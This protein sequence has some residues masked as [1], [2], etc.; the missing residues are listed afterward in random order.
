MAVLTHAHKK[1]VKS[2]AQKKHRQQQGCFLAE[3][4]KV[5]QEFQQAG[6]RLKFLFSSDPNFQPDLAIA[7]TERELQSL[8]C[9]T[10]A[11]SCLAVFAIPQ[12][13]N[14]PLAQLSVALDAIRDPGNLGALIRLCDWFGVTQLLCSEDTVDCYN[15]KVVQ[16]SMGSLARVQ[17]QYLDL[18]AYLATTAAAVYGTFL[19]GP[20]VYQQPLAEPAILVMG[21]EANGISPQVA[22]QVSQRIS[23]PRFGALQATESLNVVTAAAIIMSEF[24]RSS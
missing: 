11:N 12:Q 3:G 20:S 1:L 9:L 17:V 19:D 15:P 16:A 10:T 24:K 7:V 14:L 21:N 6:Y 4:P 2:L 8:S 18:A 23:I 13:Q 22:E 5:I